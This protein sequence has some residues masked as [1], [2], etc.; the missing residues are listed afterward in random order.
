MLDTLLPSSSQEPEDIHG[1]IFKGC[2]QHLCRSIQRLER[3]GL[4]SEQDFSA[5]ETRTGANGRPGAK[6]QT[7]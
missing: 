6:A 4:A 7:T 1:G 5:N 3:L 2:V